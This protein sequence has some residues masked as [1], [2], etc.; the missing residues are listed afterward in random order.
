[1]DESIRFAFI[2][3]AEMTMMSNPEPQPGNIIKLHTPLSEV[4]PSLPTP[5][6][7]LSVPGGD[8]S[9]S[10]A[11]TSVAAAAAAASAAVPHTASGS[12]KLVIPGKKK[13]VP[14]QKQGLPEAD[15]KAIS[16]ALAKLVR[17][18]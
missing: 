16:N 5:K 10:T 4:P 17:R 1:M 11:S 3:V 6:I 15:L 13:V 8:G 7:R 12:V 2:K 9:T 18:C 14:A